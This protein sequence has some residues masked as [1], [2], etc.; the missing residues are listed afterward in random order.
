MIRIEESF[1]TDRL[2][3]RK[4]FINDYKA[5]YNNWA[6]DPEITRYL[7]WRIHA[8]S[9]ETR[10]FINQCIEDWT[11]G[12]RF[13]FIICLKS[14]DEIIG[15]IEF[16]VDIF[17]CEVGF[18]LCKKYWRNGIMTEALNKLLYHFLSFESI[19]RVQAY[20]DIDNIGSFRLLQ[21]AGMKN[22][23]ILHRYKIYPNISS[24]PRNCHILARTK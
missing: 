1:E 3:I 18:V 16:R 9:D 6:N 24:L 10:R 17:I 8:S 21:K 11:D 19:Y 20:C 12:I 15:M 2:I 14:S 23:G 4:P 13:P 5:V 22:E 7:T